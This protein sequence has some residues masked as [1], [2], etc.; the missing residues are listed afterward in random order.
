MTYQ[1][2]HQK[3]A[4]IQQPLNK[5]TTLKQQAPP[6]N[7]QGLKYSHEKQNFYA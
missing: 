5:L 3:P 1:T 6:R 2:S 4:V 7:Q